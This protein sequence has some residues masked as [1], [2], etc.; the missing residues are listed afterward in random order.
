MSAAGFALGIDL[1]T[2]NTAAMLRWP[3]G[4]VK[5]LLFDSSPLLPSAVFARADGELI[6]GRDA[7]HHARFAPASLE[8]NPK[9]RI[10]EERVLL[11]DH[12]IEVTDLM[13]AVLRRVYAEAI[14]VTGG[15][16]P[17]VALA[18]P[19]GWGPVRRLVL[20]DA[21]KSAGLGEVTFVPEPVAAANYYT[22]VLDHGVPVGRALVVY[23]FGAGTFDASVVRRADDG[24]QVVAVDGLD[25]VGGVDI[26]AAIVA[27]L[28]AGAS[29]ESAPAWS[30]LT[31][32]ATTA[33][34]RE[35]YLL[36]DDVRTGKEMLSRTT[37]VSLRLP[38][39]ETEVTLTRAEFDGVA[40]PLVERTVRTSAAL[41]RHA[42]LTP[43][44]IAGVFLVGG[45]SRIPL[46]AAALQRTL[47][48]APTVA[49]QPELV[50]AEG[51]LHSLADAPTAGRASSASG[52]VLSSVPP[53]G[54]AA[55]GT[56]APGSAA[57]AAVEAA[58]PGSA[59]AAAVEAVAA[60]TGTV[61]QTGTA[62]AVPT[63]AEGLRPTLVLPKIDGDEL[64]DSTDPDGTSGQSAP[65]SGGPV[66]GAPVSGAPAATTPVSVA[67][68]AAAPGG[69]A[70]AAPVSPPPVRRLIPAPRQADGSPPQPWAARSTLHSPAAGHHG[71][72]LPAGPASHYD[73]HYEGHHDRY[74][75]ADHHADHGGRYPADPG[76]RYDEYRPAYPGPQPPFYPAEPPRRRGIAARV[77]LAILCTAVLLV[78]AGLAT[79]VVRLP[80]L[81]GAQPAPTGTPDPTATGTTAPASWKSVVSDGL[82]APGKWSDISDGPT[83]S[84]CVLDGHLVASKKTS[85]TYRCKGPS[86]PYTDS[87]VFVDVTLLTKGVCGGIWFRFGGSPEAGY[88]LKV[89]PEGYVLSTHGYP[90]ST[91][92]TDLQPAGP[93]LA[94]GT[95]IRVGVVAQGDSIV[96]YR[97]GKRLDT[98]QNTQFTSGRTALGVVVPYPVTDG[99]HEV[100]Y[101]NVEFRAP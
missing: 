83:T 18:H 50:V 64:A 58:A 37:S 59:G 56:A 91:R 63:G 62:A 8:P 60:Q 85:G 27:W 29:P 93:P 32:P 84:D 1:G 36:W 49:E 69:A 24:F 94:V 25:D 26:D 90:D 9:R 52:E 67:P 15:V 10:D 42:Q 48:V 77:L 95:T 22:A 51:S 100:A 41:I 78:G 55:V 66:S 20:A 79:G 30:R 33:D 12:E 82:R 74:Y 53:A 44:Q 68:A 87:A 46:V 70:A 88:L 40:G 35:R 76:G 2:S 65:V 5:P 19:A 80:R 39:L 89:C 98:V 23:D 57:A 96:L 6:L 4:R 54:A 16:E 73:G 75:D 21:A 3:D 14:R 97:N 72:P 101:A 61:A 45:S 71:S 17:A 86:S 81:A 38:L 43:P 47:T 34:A 13:A 28:R 92:I 7:L 11:G 99:P 31:N